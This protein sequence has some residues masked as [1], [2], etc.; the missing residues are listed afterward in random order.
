MMD[1]MTIRL[2]KTFD[3]DP[4]LAVKLGLGTVILIVLVGYFFNSVIL[5]LNLQ[6]EIWDPPIP[7]PIIHP[8]GTDF[9]EGYFY[10]AKVLLQLKSPYIDYNSIYP[11][12]SSV[13]FIPFRLVSVQMAYRI[14]VFALYALNLITILLAIRATQKALNSLDDGQKEPGSLPAYALFLSIGFLT[15]SSYG[16]NFSVERGNSDIYAQFFCVLALLALLRQP[17]NVWLETFLVAAATHLKLYPAILFALIFWKHRWK[18]LVPIL[19]VNLGLLFIT[20]PFNA[21]QYIQV[22][23]RYIPAPFLWGGNHSAAS[24]ARMVN[25]TLSRTAGFTLP[26][27]LFT[28]LPLVIWGGG[29]W[30]LWRRGFTPLNCALLFILS[31]PVMNVLPPTS[32]DYKLVILS[33]PVVM[34]L[35]FLVFNFGKTR[36]WLD[37]SLIIVV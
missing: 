24:F 36:R 6:A 16:F 27:F 17:G 14:Q 12:F 9:R 10:P 7:F 4:S 18:S 13:L 5:P 31:V 20:G 3:A 2:K 11:P 32:H 30:L 34:L 21:L 37:Y 23:E 29:F 1:R 8:I 19:L 22:M 35:Y 26:A 15:V 28:A 33:T 25:E